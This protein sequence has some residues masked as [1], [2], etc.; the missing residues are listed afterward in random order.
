[1]SQAGSSLPRHP[2]SRSRRVALGLAGAVMLA[3]AQFVVRPQ[4]WLGRLIPGGTAGTAFNLEMVAELRVTLA[5]GGLLL[6]ALA[7]LD[8]Q[9][10]ALGVRLARG[11]AALDGWLRQGRRWQA[12]VV[13]A[14]LAGAAIFAGFS[15]ARH[16]AFNSKAYDLGLHAQV[17]WNTSHGRLLASSIEVDNYLGDHVSPIILLLAPLY[18]VWPD[19]RALL[20]LQGVVLAAGALPLAALARR[21]LE[22]KW[23]GGAHVAALLLALNF[24]AYPALGFVNRFEFHEEVLAVP[25][26]LLAFWALEA[27]RLGVLSLA[28]ALA[29]LTKEDVGLTVAAVGL[30]TWWRGRRGRT[31]PESPHTGPDGHG[32]AGDPGLQTLGLLWA[33]IGLAWS[34][35]ALFV[36]IPAF[37][38]AGSD[39]LSRYAWLGNGPADVMATL[40]HDP[41]RVPAHLLGEPRRLWM[42]FKFLLPLGFLPLLS[43]AVLVALPSLA[44]NWLAGNLYQASIYFH[45]AAVVIPVLFAAT[46][47]GLE[48]VAR[49]RG[50]AA[51]GKSQDA[52]GKQRA[53]VNGHRNEAVLS[54][55]L[56]WLVLCAGL[57]LAF[58]RFWQPRTGQDNWENYGLTAQVDPASVAAFDSVARLLPA[59]AAVATTEA[60][61]PH[62][63]NRQQLYLLY[64]QRILEV[65]DRVDWVLVDL[66]DLRYGVR[67]RE[68]YGLLRWIADRQGLAACYFEADVV[69][70]GPGCTGSAAVAPYEARLA[71]LQQ[72]VA[73]EP[74]APVLLE[75][76]GERYFR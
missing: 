57:A 25:L 51:S 42:L 16:N 19:P 32:W 2:L 20:L 59:D 54:L 27:R 40:L 29:L 52:G 70:L 21:R 33:G 12:A 11:V 55:V 28:L 73:A 17:F 75:A 72:R 38:G 13:I 34:L 47:Y 43:P 22:A 62:L 50:K 65:P 8:R 64:D 58:D 61:A 14:F 66:S 46:V 10:A 60:Y 3:L 39:T 63:A 23:P 53:L 4:G 76:I 5:L 68:Y 69:L 31:G 18:L 48:G 67:P 45:Y 37:R 30:W 35:L 9:V 24:L 49:R 7:L 26:L 6:L 44:V 71:E 74:V 56:L 41:G 15:I 1:L 36:L